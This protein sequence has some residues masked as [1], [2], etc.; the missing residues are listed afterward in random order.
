VELIDK[1]HQRFFK[2]FLNG[3]VGS[4]GNGHSASQDIWGVN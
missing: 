4:D 3:T 2:D 1:D